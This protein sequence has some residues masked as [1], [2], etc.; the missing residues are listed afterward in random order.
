M[1]RK[2]FTI[3]SLVILIFFLGATANAYGLIPVETLTPGDL[4]VAAFLPLLAKNFS[5]NGGLSGTL[6]VFST[7]ANTTGSGGGR[8]G[9][10]FK[11]TDQDP[12]SHFCTLPEI[13]NAMMTSGVRFSTPFV[14]AW[15]DNPTLG[16]V[17]THQ[18]DG[19]AHNSVWKINNCEG[20]NVAL[21]DRFG[22]V[23][24]DNGVGVSIEIDPATGM[25]SPRPCNS[26]RRVACCRWVP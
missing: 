7:D 5:A 12:E 14:E 10:N 19:T 16:K 26:N 4:D 11:C 23:I 2:I 24:L 18:V 21:S 13:E 9:M 3:I 15:V 22:A 17:I 25:D 6:L 8:S 20:W 1:N